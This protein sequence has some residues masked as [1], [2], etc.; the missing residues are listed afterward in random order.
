[1]ANKPTQPL[2][3]LGLETSESSNIKGFN[4]SGTIEHSPG[5]VMTFPEDTEVAGLPSSVRYNP[6]SDE[7]EG[8]YENGGWLSLGGGGIRWETL[9]HAPSSNLLEGRGYL[10]NNTTGAS[11]VVLPPPT[12][13]GDSVTICDAYGKFATYPLTVSPAGN[14][15]YGSTED[16]TISTDNVS[17]TFTWSGPEQGWVVTSGVGLGQGRVYS[18]EIFTQILASETSAVTLN[19]PPTIVDVYADGKRLAESKYSLDGNVIT[20]S[21]SLPASTELQVIEYTPIQLGNGGGS[22]SST[23]TW[24][25]NGGSAIGGETEITLDIVVDDVPAID[26]NGSRQYKNLGFTFDPLT[27]KITLAQELDAEDEV[28]VIINGTPNI[29]NQIDYTLREVARVTNVKDTEVVYFSVG[30]VL[31]G[32]KVIYD[33]VTQRS[34]F[35]PELPTGTTAVSLSSSAVLVHSAGSV[36]LGALAVSREEYVTLSGTFDSG[37]VINVK[38]ELLTHTNGKYR[39]DGTLPK[40]VDAGST[41]ET[42]GGVDLGAWVSVGDASLRNDLKSDDVQLGDNLIT[43]KQPFSSA[44]TRTQHNKNSEFVSLMDFVDPNTVTTDYTI[45]IFN[46]ISDGVTGL[47]IPPGKYVVS[48]LEIGIPLQFL[49]GSSLSVTAGSTL[50][51]RGQIFAPDVRIFY[52]DGTVNI[53]GPARKNKSGAYWFGLH[54]NDVRVTAT[55]AIGNPVISAPGHFFQEG[56]GVAIE[57]VGSAAALP[58]PTNVTVAATGLNRQGPTGTT[59]YSYRVATVDE[60]GAVSVASAPITIT[61]GNDTLGKLTPSIRGLAFNVIRWDSSIGSAAVWRS[62]AGGA[63]ELLGVF[64]MGQSD[65]IANG[66]MDSGLPAITIPWIPPQPTE[67]ALPPRIITK[68]V[69]VTTNTVTVKNAPQVTGAALIRNDASVDLVSYMNNCDEA[70]IPSGVHNVTSCTVPTTVKRIFGNGYQSLIYGWGNLNSVLNCTGM[71]AGFSIEGI[72]VHSTAWHNQ[73]G[74]QLNQLTKAKVKDCYTSGNLPIFLNG[75]TRTVVSDVLVEEWIDSAI[76]DYMGNWNTIKDIDVEQGCAAI[77]QNAAAI[78]L[79]GTSTGIVRDIRTSG[80]HV[81]GVKIESGNQNWAYQNYISNSWV[82]SLHITGSSSGNRLTNNSV[83]G[84][85]HCMDYAISI[86]NDDRPNCVMHANEVAYN[87][88]YECGTSAIAVCEFGGAN[89]DIN[90]T[91]VKGNTVF[92]ANKNGIANTPEIYIEGAHVRN[93]YIGDHHSFSSGAVNYMVQEV[94]DLYGLPNNTQVG[95]LFGDTPTTGL[96]MLTGTGSA[97]LAGGGTG[98]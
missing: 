27:S 74:I 92:G 3:P 49:P 87:F 59:T 14:N 62:K 26:I 93:T 38:N 56:D 60:N 46:A 15:L 43:V 51:I 45:A 22:S 10:I 65:S 40:T 1:M 64:G 19:T 17:A 84:G 97:K 8:Y 29:Y 7:F 31:S 75:C 39:W 79:Y 33:K 5:A 34:Y 80:F 55:C 69:S 86:S 48:N 36:D 47:I 6:D 35:I 2:F 44:S 23:I 41:P 85:T 73:I 82:E 42:T 94:N 90:Y 52:G 57:H 77:P 66:L 20:F 89:P 25:Y 53:Q 18:R 50:T 88:I 61:N 13:V 9:P 12:R 11:T 28:V 91:V 32:Y 54:G 76:F 24:V 83:F 4:N 30:A 16:M 63:Y 58:I 37:A 72:R 81:Y 71:G 78:H 98:L 21:P 68:V 67:A 96:V 70:F 95:T